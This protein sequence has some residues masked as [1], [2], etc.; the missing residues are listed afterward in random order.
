MEDKIKSFNLD[1]QFFLVLLIMLLATA[2]LV[3]LFIQANQNVPLQFTLLL[4]IAAFFLAFFFYG[5]V[6]LNQAKAWVARWA[7][8]PVWVALTFFSFPSLLTLLIN[9]NSSS[10]PFPEELVQNVGG[11]FLP[12]F[13]FFYFWEA[14]VFG[15]VFLFHPQRCN[16]SWRLSWTSTLT[17]VLVG[18][19][20]WSAAMF[21]IE[22]ILQRFTLDL[23]YQTDT[24]IF[25][26]V[27][28]FALLILPVTLGFFFT[29]T[30]V[31]SRSWF[32]LLLQAVLFAVLPLRLIVSLP[33]FLFYLLTCWLKT[34]NTRLQIFILA[35]CTFNLC[36]LMLNW[37]WII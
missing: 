15:T 23:P 31:P 18:L 13:L 4:I 22:I 28:P 19:G 25:W 9:A 36:M 33:A 20:S 24:G 14:I 32:Y 3:F 1:K 8:R 21:T 6:K 7:S 34:E 12:H 5:L 17:G 2:G 11:I 10:I 35:Y 16:V 29:Y 26:P 37:Q 30:L 27:I